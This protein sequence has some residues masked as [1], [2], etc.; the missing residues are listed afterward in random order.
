MKP[1]NS[2]KKILLAVMCTIIL[3]FVFVVIQFISLM[4]PVEIPE[5][6]KNGPNES[7]QRQIADAVLGSQSDSPP[8]TS[9]ANETTSPSLASRPPV[10]FDPFNPY[11][12]HRIKT[13]G[14]I[15]KAYWARTDALGNEIVEDFRVLW[16]EEGLREILQW[17]DYS[18]PPDDKILALVQNHP[19]LVDRLRKFAQSRASAFGEDDRAYVPDEVWYRI[20]GNLWE[21]RW[22]PSTLFYTTAGSVLCARSHAAFRD[23]NTTEAISIALDAYTLATSA[24]CTPYLSQKLVGAKGE[25][26]ALVT[27]T[28]F[29]ESSLLS[30]NDLEELHEFLETYPLT[31]RNYALWFGQEYLEYR[32]RLIYDVTEPMDTRLDEIGLLSTRFFGFRAPKCWEVA[33]VKIPNPTHYMTYDLLR[34]R[35]GGERLIREYDQKWVQA[36]QSLASPYPECRQIAPTLSSRD[37]GLSCYEPL[38]NLTALRIRGL[39]EEAHANLLRAGIESILDPESG[40]G[41]NGVDFLQDRTHLWR[42]P[43]TEKSLRL[44]GTEGERTIYSLG[45]DLEDQGGE[46]LYDP[47][48][49]SI[50]AGDIVLR[51]PMSLRDEPI[52]PAASRI[53]PQD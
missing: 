8:P 38:A 16:D 35:Y 33:G 17:K 2:R 37:S 47:T 42:D 29:F 50:S 24:E 36:F 31:G 48:N 6:L 26:M 19:E 11:N 49:G 20:V 28:S 41:S 30:E 7:V 27:I 53:Q 18:R 25:Q 13:I 39:T 45:P 40:E 5:S 12:E 22:S 34:T 43:F 4:R 21:D 3:C 23:G 52:K 44:V 10:L 14:K 32:V 15:D 46:L 1:L 51:L 9:A